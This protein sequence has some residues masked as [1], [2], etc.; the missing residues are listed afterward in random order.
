MADHFNKR[1]GQLLITGA[2]GGM[3]LA[4]AML[5]ARE[6]YALLL[7]DLSQDKLEELATKCAQLGVATRCQVLDVTQA[8]SIDE[9]VT[10]LKTSGGVDAIIHTVGLSPQMAA[11]Q[12]I[13]DVDLV[14]TVAFLEQ[15][16]PYL[17]AGGCALCIAS[18]SA[19]MVPAN[20]EIEQALAAALAAD[21]SRL[22]TLT[23]AGGLLEN[24]GMAYAY[25]KKALKQYVVDRAAA[26]GKEGK[27]FV[28]LSPG[29]ID[30][31][32]GR[33]ENDAMDNFAAMRSRVALGRLGEPEDIANTALF[34]VSEK[35]AYITGCDILVDGGFVASL[36]NK[37]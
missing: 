36:S 27:R 17:K 32:M 3:G 18:M 25:A 15:A 34:L 2:T 14:G 28:S 24:S 6:G 7:A 37:S 23:S 8:A 11:A 10:V 31:A 22:N 12:R 26:W 9:L 30:T 20:E 33:L 35:A 5:A 19:Y 16:R 13:I 1:A 4:S 29:L 21:F